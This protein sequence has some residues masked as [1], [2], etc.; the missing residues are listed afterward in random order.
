MLSRVKKDLVESVAN[1]IRGITIMLSGEDF[2]EWIIRL[3]PCDDLHYHVPSKLST[4][5]SNEMSRT[6]NLE[7]R[8][9]SENP[10]LP[11]FIKIK[12]GSKYP[13]QPPELTALSYIP[14]IAVLPDLSIC[15]EML[16][17]NGGKNGMMVGVLQCLH[18]LSCYSFKVFLTAHT[19]ERIL[20]RLISLDF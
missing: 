19:S 1:P 2:S 6:S 20:E 14:H 17:F 18:I 9:L 4:S 7:V 12:F 10:P 3:T 11:L 16:R 5:P 13:F 8:L 15:L